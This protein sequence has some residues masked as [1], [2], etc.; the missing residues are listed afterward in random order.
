[1]ESGPGTIEEYD[2]QAKRWVLLNVTFPR[3]I[4]HFAALVIPVEFT[5]RSSKGISMADNGT[6]SSGNGTICYIVL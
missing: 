3:D 4:Y 5:N 1:M 2:K 6:M